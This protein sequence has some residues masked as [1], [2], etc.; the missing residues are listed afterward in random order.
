MTGLLSLH[1]GK[2]KFGELQICLLVCLITLQRSYGMKSFC[3]F[4]GE[5]VTVLW[6]VCRRGWSQNCFAQVKTLVVFDIAATIIKC[7]VRLTRFVSIEVS[8]ITSY[9]GKISGSMRAPFLSGSGMVS[10]RKCV[11]LLQCLTTELSCAGEESLCIEIIVRWNVTICRNGLRQNCL[12]QSMNVF[13]LVM[14]IS[15]TIQL[16]WNLWNYS[17]KNS[18]C[19]SFFRRDE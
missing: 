5:N 16:Q 7:K 3:F 11:V 2:E 18:F 19:R 4:F 13:V 12:V 8:Y 17:K 6:N 15:G 9:N 10:S 14:G 1:R